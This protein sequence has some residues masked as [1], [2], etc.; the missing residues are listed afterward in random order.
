MSVSWTAA[1]SGIVDPT[2]SSAGT[3]AYN[4]Q[5][6]MVYTPPAGTSNFNIT[7]NQT[8]GGSARPINDPAFQVYYTTGNCSSTFTL[9]GCYNGNGGGGVNEDQTI[10]TTAGRT[11]YIRVFNGGTP[12][13]VTT[14]GGSSNNEFSACVTAQ[15][16][17]PC[18]AIPLSTFPVSYTGTTATNYSNFMVGGCAGNY[19]ATT[20][21]GNDVFFALTVAAN[22]YYTM[23]LSGTN[24]SSIFEMS[25]LSGAC[26]GPWTC[27]TNGAW[28]GGLQTAS[29]TVS[30]MFTTT[31]ATTSSPCK[32]IY[33][34]TAGT[35]Y[36]RIDAG[37]GVSGAFTLNVNPYTV[38]GGNSCSTATGMSSGVGVTVN[39]TN[40]TYSVG[41]DDPAGALICA[42]T[43]ENTNWLQFQSN[44][45][46]TPVSVTINN[47]TC[48]DF[49][50]YTGS[51]FYAGNGQF[52][53][54]S[55]STNACGGTYSSA[56]ACTSSITTGGTYSTT[57]PN[58]AV[59]NY[60]LVWDGNGGAEC[61]YTI[62][63]T[64]INPLPI[65]LLTFKATA[66]GS[67]VYTTW[68]TATEINNDF[69]TVERSKD[70]V[71][72]STAGTVDGAGNSTENKTYAFRD[73]SPMAGQSYY[74]LKQT[75]FDGKI[76]YSDIA[77]V[78]FDGSPELT[79]SI[80]PNPS[81]KN[82]SVSLNFSGHSRET[83]TIL[84]TDITGKIVMNKTLTLTENGTSNIDLNN[85]FSAGVYFVKAIG[86]SNLKSQ[87]LI[88]R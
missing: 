78:I 44:G 29:T 25:V 68:T 59:T 31:T 19:A 36:V 74:R 11:Y 61:S 15:G 66:A 18:N 76:S 42:G 24:G 43:I 48:A 5:Y 41:P 26:A 69:F 81:D 88:I 51:G 39:N 86:E 1:G 64:N 85:E 32:I 17:T 45:N 52:G 22:S 73:I 75:D 80:V 10:S 6:W 13:T 12:R 83:I 38:T 71:E 33:F 50:Y 53:I 30:G 58:T 34:A 37:A 46:G 3:G 16:N 65:E 55:S 67:N 23:S 62:T 28:A 7:I 21:N 47:V 49:G 9:V 87:K 8:T 20:G 2:C 63:A 35:Y 84:I 40:C 79:F 27:L 56:A 14:S 72:F 82:S 77:A 4:A 70:G 54:I 57:L 60:F